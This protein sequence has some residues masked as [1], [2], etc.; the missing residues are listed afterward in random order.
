MD[1]GKKILELRKEKGITR[2]K[3]AKMIG[4]S[5]AIIGRYE[6]DERTPSVEIAKKMAK[7]LNVSLDYLVGNTTLMLDNKLIK[8]I[9]EIQSLPEEDQNHLFYLLDNVLQNVKAKKA[10]A[11]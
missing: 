1:L 6:R 3:L 9:E 8:K 5:G 11:S 10:F 2:E 4:T 7:A